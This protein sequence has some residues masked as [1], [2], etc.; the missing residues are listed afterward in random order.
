MTISTPNCSQNTVLCRSCY[1]LGNNILLNSPSITQ[2]GMDES[3][4]IFH[5]ES[6]PFSVFQDVLAK[7]T[8]KE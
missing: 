3:K 6:K 2:T 4:S 8:E 7:S 1:T 5:A